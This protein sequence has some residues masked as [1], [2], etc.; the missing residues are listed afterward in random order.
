LSMMTCALVTSSARFRGT[1]QYPHIAPCILS[2]L[3]VRVSR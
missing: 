3:L 2:L 1:A